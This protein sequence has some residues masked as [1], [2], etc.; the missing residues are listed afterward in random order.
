MRAEGSRA[1]ALASLA[2]VAALVLSLIGGPALA[3][4]AP[5]TSP[6]VDSRLALLGAG[7]VL[8]VVAFGLLTGPLGTAPLAGGSLAPVP[9]AVSLGSRLIAATT[10]AAGGLSAAWLYSKVTGRPVDMA[11]G[12]TLAAGAL[13][14]VAIGNLLTGGGL[15]SIPYYAGAGT[16]TAGQLASAA[17]QAA[18]RIYVVTSG[19]LGVWAADWWYRSQ[20]AP[21]R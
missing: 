9:V 10:A 2:L 7:A 8:G 18:S 19:V 17:F 5:E 15:G 1:T 16:A 13:G 21:T 12:A 6:P 4:A 3:D 11:Y 20:T 14:G